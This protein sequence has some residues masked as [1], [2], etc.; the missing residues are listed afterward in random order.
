MARLVTPVLEYVASLAVG[1]IGTG[2]VVPSGVF[3]SDTLP[4]VSATAESPL[5]NATRTLALRCDG[6]S[7]LGSPIGS[8]LGSDVQALIRATLLL[9]Y[10]TGLDL[11]EIDGDPGDEF[12][13]AARGMAA[14]D[15]AVILRAL[16]WAQNQNATLASGVT[17]V[18]IRPSAEHTLDAIENVVISSQPLEITAQWSPIAPWDLG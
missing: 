13:S 16:T 2:R 18:M 7:L 4:V 6:S 8:Q 10:R 5:I 9:T 12:A 3:A 1:T 15:M 14:D 11:P 17:V